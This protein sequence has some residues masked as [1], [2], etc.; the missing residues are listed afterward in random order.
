MYPQ[1]LRTVCTELLT[2][3]ENDPALARLVRAKSSSHSSPLTHSSQ[4]CHGPFREPQST[5]Q[6]LLHHTSDFG[7]RTTVAC[8][9][10]CTR[11]KNGPTRPPRHRQGRQLWGEDRTRR[12]PGSRGGSD[13]FADIGA[14]LATR[15]SGRYQPSQSV[16]VRADACARPCARRVRT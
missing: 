3:A 13:P 1:Y 11:P 15:S 9:L 14:Q 12:Q 6:E 16:S 8:L 4:S 10:R 2:V 5:V 7:Y